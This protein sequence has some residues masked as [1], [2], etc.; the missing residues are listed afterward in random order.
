MI[1]ASVL[2]DAVYIAGGKNT[3]F[4]SSYAEAI[5]F[6]NEAFKHCKVIGADEFEMLGKT[7]IDDKSEENADQGIIINSES[8][9]KNF[10]KVFIDIK[11]ETFVLAFYLQSKVIL[12]FYS[13]FVKISPI[14]FALDIVFLFCTIRLH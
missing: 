13:K 8:T 12:I 11:A 6:I 14:K 2:F 7:I 3:G 1:A 9:N 5:E 10:T 4:L